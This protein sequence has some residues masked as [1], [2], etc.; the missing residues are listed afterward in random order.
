MDRPVNSG[1]QSW[2]LRCDRR[3][4]PGINRG[5][6]AKS[7]SM[8]TSISVGAFAVPISRDSLSDE[9]E[10]YDDDMLRPW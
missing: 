9:I 6:A 7:S 1:A 5:S 2:T 3:V 8:R 4:A 10:V